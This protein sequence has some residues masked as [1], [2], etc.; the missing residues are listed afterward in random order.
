M[1]EAGTD[2]RHLDSLDETESQLLRL[3]AASS[4]PVRGRTKL[5]K[6]GFFGEFYRPDDDELHPT[7]RVG[8][9]DDYVIYDHG[10]FSR[11]LMEAF[12]ELKRRGLLTEEA[13]LTFMGNRRSDVSLT[14]DGERVGARLDD[15]ERTEQIVT[16]FDD[17]S[18]TDAEEESL[19]RLEI[20][21]HEK[22]DYRL[23]HVSEIIADG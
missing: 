3:V 12:D 23:T 11:D 8:A 21:R 19:E 18:A 16:A 17:Y 2:D 5:M 13:A 10:P 6:L 9:F 14:E 4:G 7:E 1:T 20:E 15:D 22:D